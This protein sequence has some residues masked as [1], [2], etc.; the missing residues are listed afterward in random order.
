[1]TEEKCTPED[2]LG[3]PFDATEL[4][5][6]G[7]EEVKKEKIEDDRIAVKEESSDDNGEAIKLE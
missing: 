1:M 3:E 6:Q 2:P 5:E 7:L 4:L